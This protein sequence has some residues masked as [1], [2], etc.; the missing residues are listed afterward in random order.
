MSDGHKHPRKRPAEDGEHGTAS[1]PKVARIPETA[2]P[3]AADSPVMLRKAMPLPCF[4]LPLVCLV[5]MGTI[6]EPVSIGM[7]KSAF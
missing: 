5:K 4:L 3:F 1:V 2:L 6:A 7:L